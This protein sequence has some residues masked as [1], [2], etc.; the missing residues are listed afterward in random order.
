MVPESEPA[1][2]VKSLLKAVPISAIMSVVVVERP[3]FWKA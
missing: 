1:Q 3:Y 2:V